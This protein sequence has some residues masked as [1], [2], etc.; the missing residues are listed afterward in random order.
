[1]SNWQT[2]AQAVREQG[3]IERRDWSP[4]GDSLSWRIYTYWLGGGGDPLARENFCHYWRV[5]L[6]WSPLSR[7]LKPLKSRNFLPRLGLVVLLA[8]VTLLAV[9]TITS[10]GQFL[11]IIG[12]ATICAWFIAG[13]LYAISELVYRFQS[14]PDPSPLFPLIRELPQG[15]HAALIVLFL[16]VI[17]LSAVV[18]LLLSGTVKIFT[19]LRLHER[20]WRIH[21]PRLPWLNPAIALIAIVASI[22]THLALLGVP[23][24]VS[25]A[26]LA[27]AILAILGFATLITWLSDLMVRWRKVRRQSSDDKIAVLNQDVSNQVIDYIVRARYEMEHPRHRDEIA[28]FNSWLIRYR[29]YYETRKGY[30][31]YDYGYR[32][33]HL[34]H[35]QHRFFDEY[36]SRDQF[37]D[38]DYVSFRFYPMVESSKAI[39][40]FTQVI[41]FGSF[42]W[43]VVVALKWR[44]CP[45]VEMPSEVHLHSV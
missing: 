44:S 4:R 29:L 21:P 33:R 36:M 41:D 20:L 19:D 1:M 14:S 11:P 42:L 45:I 5:V 22:I 24:A 40:K 32:D 39:T 31:F 6:F 8:V 26:G 30:D 9:M 7:L 37:Y 18:G 16:P 13:V 23:W 25:V 27:L 38:N 34:S 43:S 35:L 28:H 2:K 3:S 15:L 17:L 10:P 12:K